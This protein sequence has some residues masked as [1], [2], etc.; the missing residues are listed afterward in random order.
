MRLMHIVP[1]YAL[2]LF[3]PT[4]LPAQVA[5]PTVRAPIGA[6]RAG[7][8]PR[9]TDK[10]LGTAPGG[11]R[12][13]A[14]TPTSV[15]LS[16]QAVPGVLG[17]T[18]V[19]GPA[20]ST[21]WLNTDPITTT[22]FTHQGLAPNTTVQ[23]TVFSE[24]GVDGQF[25]NAPAPSVS[26]TTSQ[27]VGPTTFTAVREGS[28]VKLT[29][30]PVPGAVGYSLG[31]YHPSGGPIL[32]G[33]SPVTVTSFTDADPPAGDQRYVLSTNYG[34]NIW[35]PPVSATVTLP[36]TRGRYRVTINGF[37]AHQETKDH[38]LEVDGKRDEVFVAAYVSMFD[39][40]KAPVTGELRT[41]VYGDVNGFQ[42]R[43]KAGSA[44][45]MGGIQSGDKYPAAANPWLR[46]GSPNGSELPLLLWEGE[47]VQGQNVLFF[48]P[49]IWEFDG[50][51]EVYQDWL[52]QERYKSGNLA[53][54]G[55]QNLLTT[56]AIEVKTRDADNAA[57]AFYSNANVGG[58][59]RN[60]PIGV[61]EE[62]SNAEFSR[63]SY[64]ARSVALT[65][66]AIE[67]ALASSN[68]I[69]GTPP[70]YLAIQYENP[71]SLSGRYT[72]YL[73]LERIE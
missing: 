28:S 7:I 24:Y 9:A 26:A 35:A 46:S 33:P 14:V 5:R 27:P 70:G 49:T 44:S 2:C 69:G 25:R 56:S 72:L 55:Y 50:D 23:Y 41:P 11:V 29:W 36:R 45:S 47:L 73:Q 40:T 57:K 16:W 31:R 42:N 1:A 48:V 12:V 34:G 54:G 65:V 59:A 22:S 43:R 61:K 3:A 64:Y 68:G 66:D 38:M 53:R 39:K 30:N 4:L 18:V 51:E 21:E 10:P 71:A 62:G 15:T 52:R 6:T 8:Q 58:M 17:Y 20:T 60:H 67:A 19:R 13:S 37:L 63:Y 32:T